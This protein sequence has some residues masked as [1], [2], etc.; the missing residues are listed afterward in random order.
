MKKII[1]VIMV[2]VLMATSVG[3]GFIKDG[4][5]TITYLTNEEYNEIVEKLNK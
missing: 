2:V 3:C 5:P 4:T 1:F